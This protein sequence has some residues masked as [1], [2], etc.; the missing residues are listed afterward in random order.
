MSPATIATAPTDRALGNFSAGPACLSENVMR[1]AAAEFV[2]KDGT[3][4]G[5][6]EVCLS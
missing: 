6:M 1:T 2:N 5:I 3:G 4:I